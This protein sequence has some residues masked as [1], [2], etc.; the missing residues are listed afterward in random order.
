MVDPEDFFG[1]LFVF[2][3]TFLG[4]SIGP[5]HFLENS[6][7]SHRSTFCRH[8]WYVEKNAVFLTFLKKIGSLSF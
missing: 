7:I 2:L 3:V 5:A 8:F 6:K 1:S 4:P